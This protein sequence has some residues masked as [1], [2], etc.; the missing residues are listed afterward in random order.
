[1]I[2]VERTLATSVAP[3]VA[4]DY[5]SDFGNTAVWD[6][7]VRQATRNDAG[8][9]APG[10]SWHQT[11]RLL[12]ITTEMMYT[13]VEFA[14]GRLVFHGR[15][16]GATCVDTV[17][18]RPAGT[19]SEVTYRIELEMHGLAKLAGPVIKMEFEKLGTAGAG[20]LA[21][22]LDQLAPGARAAELQFP[23]DVPHSPTLPARSQEAQA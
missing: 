11:C 10:A 20:A 3:G 17:A 7:A 12:G 16:E 15:N 23:A 22:A 14:P 4:L 5:L 21:A 1:M 19:G 8:P 6:P 18:V 2:V 9:I 13:L